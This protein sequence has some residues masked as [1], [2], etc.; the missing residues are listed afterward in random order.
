MSVLELGQDSARGV[1]RFRGPAAAPTPLFGLSIAAGFV[2]PSRGHNA[3]RDEEHNGDGGESEP[4]WIESTQPKSI[5][6][7]K[8][9][10][11]FDAPKQASKSVVCG[12][13]AHHLRKP[14]DR[15]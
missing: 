2:K 6:K 3:E 8:I 5:P 12:Q 13:L 4:F 7:A 15:A 9:A 1:S 11:P 14:S 10:R